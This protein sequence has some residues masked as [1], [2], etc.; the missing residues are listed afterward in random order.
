[1]QYAHNW[2][3]L[4]RHH[5]S[6]P[7]LLTFYIQNS[8][9]RYKGFILQNSYLPHVIYRVQLKSQISQ[10]VIF[11]QIKIDICHRLSTELRAA[12]V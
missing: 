1:M 4:L 11:L 6:A 12:I 9:I 10:A 5:N 8:K 7:L 2:D 3:I